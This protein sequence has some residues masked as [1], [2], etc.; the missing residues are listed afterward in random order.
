MPA[1]ASLQS[2]AGRTMGTSWSVRFC[3]TAA[4]KQTMS[5]AV[6]RCLDLVVNQMSL[7]EP[8]SDISRLNRH[9]LGEWL[10]VAA[11]FDAVIAAALRIAHLTGGAFDPTVGAPVDRWGF[12]PMAGGTEPPSQHETGMQLDQIGWHQL[13]HDAAG[14]RVRRLAPFALDLNGI[15]KGFAVDAVM[16]TLGQHGLHHALVEIGGELSGTG[17]KPDGSPWWVDVEARDGDGALPATPLRVALHEL[18]VATSGVER[19]V[20]HE[21]RALSHTIDPATGRPIANRTISATVL[22]RSCMDADAFATAFMVMDPD[23]A[24]DCADRLALP[25]A[26]RLRAPRG[27]ETFERLS[28]SMRGMLA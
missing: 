5:R 22:H 2:L 23:A 27:N 9:P 19:R 7:W 28:S 10:N 11:E 26:I 17:I 12:G 15:A 14:R 24:I 21:G 13:D 25:V 4:A 16:A 18:A 3:G 8:G 1:G 20:F 6:Q